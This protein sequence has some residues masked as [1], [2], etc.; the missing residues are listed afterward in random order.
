[1]R[2]GVAIGI[3]VLA[4]C[5]ASSTLRVDVQTDLV[6]RAE[7]DGFTVRVGDAEVERVEVRE[8]SDYVRGVRLIE[9]AIR[10][11]EHRMRVAAVL[12][13]DEVVA[14]DVV[15]SVAGDTGITVVLT[16]SCRDVTCPASDPARVACVGGACVDP[17]CTPEAP[18]TCETECV[19]DPECAPDVGCAEG[20]CV[21][22]VCLLADLG[23]CAPGY[24]DPDEGCVGSVMMSDAGTEEDGGVL[25]AGFTDS[26]S[27]P[28]DAGPALSDAGSDAGL[29]GG[30]AAGG[31]GGPDAGGDAGPDAGVDAGADA[32]RGGRD[33]GPC[34]SCG[35]ACTCDVTCCRSCAL[36][37]DVT[38]DGAE[39][40][41]EHTG[42]AGSTGDC[43]SGAGCEIDARF[44]SGNSYTCR[45]G[46]VCAVECQGS[47]GCGMIC[48]AT[49]DCTLFCGTPRAIGCG[50]DACGHGAVQ[51][52]GDGRFVCSES[53]C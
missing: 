32:G 14:R 39:C 31:D 28:D 44:S 9:R 49:S 53:G 30:P 38:C 27:P 18:E 7:V 46:S 1:V 20:I 36:S 33:A 21:N 3:V 48:D 40:V 12:G 10:D 34:L 6:P 35:L 29:D 50:F 19:G 52:C 24:C 4:G 22:G 37:C 17:R 25:D 45:G 11:G 42:S 26:G 5:T 47:I 2:V 43:H 51:D 13:E 41:L 8:G 15:F 16:R 23:D